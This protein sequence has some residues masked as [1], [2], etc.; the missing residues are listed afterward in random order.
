MDEAWGAHLAFHPALP[1]HAIAAGA[2]LVIS[3]TH[4]SLGSLSGSAM[5]HHG[6][7]AE[8]RLPE[9]AVNEALA[10][11]ETTSPNALALAS[12]DAA[13]AR[14]V[15]SGHELLSVT[16]RE[17]ADTRSRLAE[18]ARVRV[19][20]PEVVGRS[21]VHAFDPLRLTID[22]QTTGRDAREIAAML[23]DHSGIA[24]EF[25]TDRL[26]VAAFG[27]ADGDLGAGAALCEALVPALLRVPCRPRQEA[28]AVIP[29]RPGAAVLEPRNAWLSRRLRVPSAD[30]VGQIAAETLSPYPP[31]I[32][33]VLPGERLTPQ[34]VAELRATVEAGAV[35]RGAVDGLR[36]IAIVDAGRPAAASQAPPGRRAVRRRRVAGMASWSR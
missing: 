34:I 26:L 15:S 3:S 4:K 8:R 24:L 17:I 14:A 12:L 33:A 19:L 36:M 35:V 5:L 22:L 25:A 32:P 7:D 10:L 1:E 20:G 13:R 28:H 18:I 11:T 9:A 2:D 29:T 27:L 23:N 30:A 21:G 6:P 16:L 31:G